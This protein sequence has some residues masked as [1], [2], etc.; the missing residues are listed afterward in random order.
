MSTEGWLGFK[1][2]KKGREVLQVEETAK[3]KTS[4]RGENFVHL[5][6]PEFIVR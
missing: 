4:E 6:N 3:A 1:P 5:R 2:V